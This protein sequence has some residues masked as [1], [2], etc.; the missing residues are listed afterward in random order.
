MHCSIVVKN[1][2]AL[3]LAMVT[4]SQFLKTWDWFLR[5]LLNQL[6]N[7]FPVT[8]QSVTPVTAPPDQVAGITRNQHS[9]QLQLVTSRFPTTAISLT[10]MN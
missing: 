5:S 4:T 8:L 10:L 2:L 7:P 1:Q 3:P 6:W 9:A